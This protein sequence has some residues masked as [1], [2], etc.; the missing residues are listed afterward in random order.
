MAEDFK[1]QPKPY[2]GVKSHAGFKSQAEILLA[3]NHHGLAVP[4]VNQFQN[5]S[6]K[7]QG[8]I[9]EKAKRSILS[10]KDTDKPNKRKNRRNHKKARDDSD[11]DYTF[12]RVNAGIDEVKRRIKNSMHDLDHHSFKLNTF[13]I[14]PSDKNKH[15][16]AN[17]CEDRIK[18]RAR[19]HY[20]QRHRSQKG[21]S[22]DESKGIK[23]IRKPISLRHSVSQK[24]KIA[25]LP[26]PPS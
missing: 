3:N 2:S 1:N 17:R 4:T 13:G 23:I 20:R 26:N 15:H 6:P 25:L 19:E 11:E 18:H 16:S 21:K 12:D 10:V 24:K 22:N 5:E 14:E 7:E 9:D 8:N